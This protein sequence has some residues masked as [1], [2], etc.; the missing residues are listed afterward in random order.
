[1][2]WGGGTCFLTILCSAGK[3]KPLLG[4]EVVGAGEGFRVQ[5]IKGAFVSAVGSP[6]RG[7]QGEQ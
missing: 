7:T 2:G 4:L 5:L 1:M 3:Q 6:R